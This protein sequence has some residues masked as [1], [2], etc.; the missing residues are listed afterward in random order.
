M[1]TASQFARCPTLNETPVDDTVGRFLE[2]KLVGARSL[3]GKFFLVAMV[4]YSLLI[5]FPFK[6]NV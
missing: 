2:A 5:T 1:F 3:I 6:E 4:F